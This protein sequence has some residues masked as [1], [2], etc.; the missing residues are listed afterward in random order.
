MM[1][2]QLQVLN[3]AFDSQDAEFQSLDIDAVQENVSRFMQTVFMLEKGLPRN[4]L[5][6]K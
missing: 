2:A 5:V 4:E 1:I 6:P 3:V